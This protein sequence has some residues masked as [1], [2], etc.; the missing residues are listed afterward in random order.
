V[1]A[2]R[3]HGAGPVRAA[4][5]SREAAVLAVDEVVHRGRSLEHALARHVDPLPV[6]ARPAGRE[7]S[8]GTLRWLPRLQ[9]LA[10]RLQSRPFRSRDRVLNTLLWTGLY[11]LDQ[12]AEPAYAVVDRSVAIAADLGRRWAGAAINAQLRRFLDQREAIAGTLDVRESHALPAWLY[13][14]IRRQWPGRWQEIAAAHTGRPPLT[15][16]VNLHRTTR[17]RYLGQLGTHGLSAG[18]TRHAPAGLIVE[19]PLPVER[20]P[21]F[22]DGLV[23]V[24]DESAQLVRDVMDIRDGQRV[25]DACAAPG[26]KTCHLLESADL[27]L[28]ALDREA[29]IG[30]VRANLERLGL[31]ARVVAGD[32]RHPDAWWDGQPFDRILVDAPCSG[33][34]VVRRHP[35]IGVL[36][37]EE[38][39]AASARHQ[40]VLLDQLWPL[41]GR[42]GVLTYSTCSIL[43][44]ENDEVVAAFVARTPDARSA[45]APVAGERTR[46]G[47]RRATGEDGGDGF[48]YAN[49]RHR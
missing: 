14:R 19:P 24:Q 38:D 35:D 33:S 17:D 39:I 2:T 34:G 21:G 11:Q 20:I 1:S 18:P 40:G 36:R 37:R 10:A 7:I 5:D 43:D 6:S 25:L 22:I 47:L 9:A 44:E 8:Y 27:E 16:R 31:E 41:L 29:R 42:G 13:D 3:K 26:G 15:L 28:V 48:Y 46:H 32:A 45:M 49:L 23:S 12:S 4:G 30:L